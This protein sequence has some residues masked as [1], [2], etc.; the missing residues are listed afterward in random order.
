MRGGI[1]WDGSAVFAGVRYDVSLRRTSTQPAK[2]RET[3]PLLGKSLPI[4]PVQ[5]PLPVRCIFQVRCTSRT[6]VCHVCQSQL[7]STPAAAVSNPRSA[8]RQLVSA[9]YARIALDKYASLA[10]P[11][12]TQGFSPLDATPNRSRSPSG[13]ALQ[14]WTVRGPAP[15]E[16]EGPRRRASRPGLSG[17]QPR[18][19]RPVT[20]KG[21]CWSG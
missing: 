8:P 12:W 16:L 19:G 15:R 11:P 3:G 13:L 14:V 4:D 6:C 1:V 9:A 10:Y 17:R 7:V 2:T 5:S 20:R 18:H 21:V